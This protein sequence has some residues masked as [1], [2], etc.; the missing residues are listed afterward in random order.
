MK[1]YQLAHEYLTLDKLSVIPCGKDKRPLL[2]SWKEFQSRKATEAELLSWFSQWPEANIGIVTGLISGITV[3]DIDTYKQP[4]TPVT[5]FP[6]TRTVRTGNGG[7]HL[8][9]KYK[10]GLTI[11]ANAYP[12]LPG[13]DIRSDGGFIIAAGSVTDYEKDGKRMGGEYTVVND[14]LPTDFPEELF[15]NNKPKRKLSDTV[16]VKTGARND[17]ITSVIGKLLQ[18]HSE[19]VWYSE[20]LPAIE[21]INSTYVPPLPLD[22]VHTTFNSVVNLERNRRLALNDGVEDEDEKE[23]R[24]IFSKNKT[25]GT[26]ELAKYMVKKY[27][28]ITIGEKEREMFVYRGGLY[29]KAENEIIFPEIQRVLG[30]LV[31]KSAKMETYS[32]IADMTANNREVFTTASLNLIPLKNGVYDRELKT[33]LPH[34]PLYRFTYQFPIKFDPQAVCP[35]TETFFDQVLDTEQRGVVEEWIGYYFLRNYMFKKAIIF[36]GDG[37]TGKTTLLQ[38]IFYLLGLGNVSGIPLQKMA[39]DRFAAAQMF[40]KHGNIVDELDPKDISGTGN[41]KIAT[42]GGTISGEYKF[43]NQ[44]VFS[45]FAKLTFAC[46]KIPDVKDFDDEAYFNRWL[47]VRFNKTIE[48]KIPNF[49]LSLT[50]EEERSGLFNL[51]MIALERLIDNGRFT[52]GRNAIDTKIEM[53]RSGSSIAV[54]AAEQMEQSNGEEITKEALYEAYCDFCLDKGLAAETIKMVGTKLPFYVSYISEGYVSVLKNGKGD[55]MRGWR[56]ARVKNLA[57]VNEKAEEMYNKL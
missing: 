9:Y 11:S 5:T 56:N 19:S 42:G 4:S 32:K 44:F 31:T 16:N 57:V 27:D 29:F 38:V 53:M 12:H 55:Q 50:S 24:G 15:T 33:L 35:K 23:V 17:S 48:K 3:V 1:N 21:K 36:V 14:E 30:H 28:I 6:V 20:V 54:F 18:A 10:E 22:E 13:V 52:Y 47:I 43:G 26:Y 45:N 25:E 7:Y 37:D 8:I 46:N 39:L 2:T 49:V 51:A 40:E 41:F 34:S